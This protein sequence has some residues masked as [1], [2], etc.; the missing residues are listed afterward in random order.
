M[1]G[2]EGLM[3]RRSLSL[4]VFGTGALGAGCD[5]EALEPDEL[6]FRAETFCPKWKCGF[7]AAEINGRSLQALNINGVANVD[8]VRIVGFVPPPLALLGNYTLGFEHDELVAT[9]AF[10]SKLKGAQLVGGIILVQVQLGLVVPVTIAGHTTVPSWA[11]GGAPIGA[12]TLVYPEVSALLGV[13][14]VCSGSLLDPLASDATILGG[15]TYDEASKTVLANQSGWFTIACAGSAAAKM[16]L[17]GYGPQSKFPGTTA[18]AS[19][20]ARQA[21]LKMITADY[22]GTGESYTTNGTAVVWQNA[23]GTVNSANWHTPG[24]VEAVWG[25]GGALCLDAT[26]IPEVAVGCELPSCD[27]LG[28]ADGAWLTR[29]AVD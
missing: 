6:E 20:A 9:G 16:K 23:E 2:L 27:G 15:E 29:V 19:P 26:R 25:P 28:V 14:N 12:Y 13:K 21:T 8:G 7:N 1:E 4:L 3:F 24:A 18:P 5:G 10:G 17:L 11:S 22:C